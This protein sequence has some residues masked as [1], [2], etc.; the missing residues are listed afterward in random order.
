MQAKDKVQ[1]ELLRSLYREE[2]MEEVF[3]TPPHTH[4]HTHTHTHI[5]THTHTHMYI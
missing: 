1:V 5:H 3:I 2:L 4:T